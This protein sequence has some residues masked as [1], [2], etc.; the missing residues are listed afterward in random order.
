MGGRNFEFD[1]HHCTRE[2][3]RGCFVC[4]VISSTNR[5]GRSVVIDLLANAGL[6]TGNRV[7]VVPTPDFSKPANSVV[8]PPPSDN[9]IAV[10]RQTLMME[11]G[12]TALPVHWERAFATWQHEENA[13]VLVELPPATTADALVYSAGVPNVLWLGAA[14]VA[15]SKTTTQCV[16]S[17]RNSGCHLIGAALN[18]CS[19]F[20]KRA[21]GWFL[22]AASLITVTVGVRAATDAPRRRNL[23]SHECVVRHEISH[24]RTVAGK[25]D[26]RVGRRS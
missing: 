8:A 14:N 20:N 23:R 18:M 4:G 1:S 2:D 21:A 24:A 11:A 15:D 12:N 26:A 25:A 9:S 16:N 22:L 10:A 7:L 3:R 5:E 19:S 6:R 13:L 17:L